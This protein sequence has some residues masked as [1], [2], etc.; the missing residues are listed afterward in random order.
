M[1][2]LLRTIASCF[3]RFICFLILNL[4]WGI[5]LYEYCDIP[6]DISSHLSLILLGSLLVIILFSLYNYQLIWLKTLLKCYEYNFKT[7]W[8]NSD[9]WLWLCEYEKVRNFGIDGDPWCDSP[10]LECCG[11]SLDYESL[12]IYFPNGSFM[13]CI[14]G[15]RQ[16]FTWRSI[17]HRRALSSKKVSRVL[18]V[19]DK[20]P[21]CGLNKL[22]EDHLM[23]LDL[24]AFYGK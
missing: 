8:P 16:S 24:V 21:C 14:T 6:A 23:N 12:R 22:I 10:Q 1:A 4:F 19:M 2:E 15:Y 7:K 9:N 13:D 17:I 3:L 5:L 18:L 11:R 20:T